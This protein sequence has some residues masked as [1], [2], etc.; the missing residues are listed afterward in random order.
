[1]LP[2]L[3]ITSDNLIG[4]KGANLLAISQYLGE[5]FSNFGSVFDKIQVVFTD[6]KN[7]QKVKEGIKEKIESIFKHSPYLNEFFKEDENELYPGC[8]DIKRSL[9]Y[10]QLKNFKL[11]MKRLE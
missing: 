4:N 1:M 3:V 10:A 11:M 6:F 5:A 9:H 8:N 7:N 2:L